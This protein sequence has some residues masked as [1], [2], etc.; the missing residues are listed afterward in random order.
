MP[1]RTKR[2]SAGELTE[3]V[4]SGSVTA[5]EVIT[6]QTMFYEAGPTRMVLLDLS[7]ADMALLTTENMRQ[8]IRRTATLGLERQDGRTVIVA[9]APLQYGLGRMAESYGEIESI[10]YTLRVFLKR[11]DAVRWLEESDNQPAD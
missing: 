9:P 10:P 5:E 3:H 1:I 8:F 2:D 4:I 6:C 7:E 11:D